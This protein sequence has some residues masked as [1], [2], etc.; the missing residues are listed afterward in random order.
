MY[1]THML[2]VVP[3]VFHSGGPQGAFPLPVQF[4]HLLRMVTDKIGHYR[5]NEMG[6]WLECVNHDGYQSVS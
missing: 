5:S 6:C 3:A 4:M 2:F 1:R